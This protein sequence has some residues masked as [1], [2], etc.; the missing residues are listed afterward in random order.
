MPKQLVT[1]IGL[2]VSLGV[3]ALGVFL[4][5]LPLY[6]QAVGV[7]AETASVAD[8]NALYQTQV[9]TLEAQQENLGA[10]EANVSELRSQIP[11][12]SQLDGV[13]EVVAR[14]SEASGVALTAVTAGEQVVF[15]ARTGVEADEAAAAVPAP[16]PSATPEASAPTGAAPT[17]DAPSAGSSSRDGRQQVDFV[18]N[19]TAADMAQ[20]TAFLDALRAGPRLLNSIAATS[21]LTGEGT[22]EVQVN[23]LSYIDAEG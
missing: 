1:A 2:I 23:A 12:S 17:V 6:F 5:A 11:A 10:I 18:I 9:D 19:A 20:A 15:V 3:I 21:N 4:V 14:A 8:A 13:F 7:D 22:V 16:A